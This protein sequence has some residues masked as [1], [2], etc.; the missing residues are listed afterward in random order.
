MADCAGVRD[1]TEPG[2][3]RQ[4]SNESE[5]AAGFDIPND[6]NGTRREAAFKADQLKH[7]NDSVVG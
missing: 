7:V 1:S 4:S 2:L 3:L 6:D 5:A